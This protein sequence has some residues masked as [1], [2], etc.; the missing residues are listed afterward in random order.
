V[1]G[2]PFR[3]F[4]SHLH[5]DGSGRNPYRAAH[6]RNKGTTRGHN[7]VVTE[8]VRET[9]RCVLPHFGAGSA[10]CNIRATL[11]VHL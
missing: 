9:R 8:Q 11:S 6:E 3:G 2:Q 1:K 5:R 10:G 7:T 4:K